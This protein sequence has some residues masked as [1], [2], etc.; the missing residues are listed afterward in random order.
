M[1]DG[2]VLIQIDLDSGNVNQQI[3]QTRNQLDG[4]ER[5]SNKTGTGMGGM[6]NAA[7]AGLGKFGGQL[8]EVGGTMKAFGGGAATTLATVGISVAGVVKAVQSGMERMDAMTKANMT[9]KSMGADAD[10]SFGD[11]KTAAE[12][13]TKG[14]QM[15]L[16]EFGQVVDKYLA[17]G[18][19]EAAAVATASVNA[20]VRGTSISMPTASKAVAAF[21]ATGMDLHRSVDVFKDMSKILAGVGNATEEG[22]AQAGDALAKM[23]ADGR[24]TL[25]TFDQFKLAVP[26]AM[27]MVSDATGWSMDEVRKN[28]EGG[29]MSWAQFEEILS[30]GASKIDAE[31][32]NMGGVMAATGVTFEGIIGNI[33]SA[34]ARFGESIIES[35]GEDKIKDIMKSLITV[36]DNLGKQVGPIITNI[37]TAIE[38]WWP[39]IE[40]ILPIIP[41]VLAVG[42]SFFTMGTMIEK[43]GS[44]LTLFSNP[45]GMV[46]GIIYLLVTAFAVAYASSETFRNK[47]HEF[48]QFIQPAIDALIGWFNSIISSIKKFWDENGTQ[49]MQAVGKIC[50]VIGQVFMAL[51]FILEPVWNQIKNIVETAI[52][53]IMGIIKVVTGII[54]GDWTMVWNGIKDIF[55]AVW[56]YIKKTF[57]NAIDFILRF[58]GTTKDDLLR[59]AKEIIDGIINWFASLPGRALD[60]FNEMKNAVLNVVRNIDLFQ[61]G[62]DIIQGLING[63][64]SMFNNAVNAVKNIGGA[65]LDGVKGF[66]GIKSPSSV[67]RDQIGK[68]IPEG[69]AIG[70][71]T[72]IKGVQQAMDEMNNIILGKA[73]SPE[74]AIAG[75]SGDI[76]LGT[77]NTSNRT[78]VNHNQFNVEW[79]GEE[80][81]VET[82]EKIADRMLKDERGSF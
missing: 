79:S 76:G 24:V 60:K 32:S 8:Q 36:F 41:A 57:S 74:L 2:K 70:I 9:F 34:F 77:T 40:K 82:L 33:K 54:N 7:M 64:G 14:T 25:R 21:N 29:S 65:M 23:A 56:E 5:N 43:A 47:V 27:K 16:S 39:V 6:F 10:K 38:K 72:N 13:M 80:D 15:S 78:V 18:Y 53:I 71:S 51:V 28:M 30:K 17:K 46:I 59:K 45:V 19:P 22:L 4:L 42:V 49:I 1:A 48:L 67:F 44:F 3:A 11:V 50:E 26:N 37:V 61:I 35:I 12:R 81:I 73:L 31:W 66:L 68:M 55:G 20:F 63:V 62:K 75:V 52:N 69:L 58:F